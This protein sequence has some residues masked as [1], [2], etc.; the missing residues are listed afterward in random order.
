MYQNKEYLAL[1]KRAE[2]RRSLKSVKRMK[3]TVLM[4]AV[5]MTV[6]V[7]LAL[8]NFCVANQYIRQNELRT[9]QIRE[10]CQK[11]DSLQQHIEIMEGDAWFANCLPNE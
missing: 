11:V 9:A 8:M 1:C 10:M 2:Q 7:S 6:T 3:L 5:A 4:M